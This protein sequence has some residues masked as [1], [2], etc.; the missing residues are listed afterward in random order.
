MDHD[1]YLKTQQLWDTEDKPKAFQLILAHCHPEVKERIENTNHWT[2]V[3]TDQDVIELLWL[4]RNVVYKH[5]EVKQ[6][7]MSF[8]EEYIQYFL[9][10]Q[11]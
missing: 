10:F 3:E 11:K 6:G 9:A 4:I 5:K 8:V 2:Q 7:T 1:A